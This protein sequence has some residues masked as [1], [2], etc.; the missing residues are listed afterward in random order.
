MKMNGLGGNVLDESGRSNQPGADDPGS[1]LK[2][3][4]SESVMTMVFC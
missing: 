4:R 1:K 2:A 3:T